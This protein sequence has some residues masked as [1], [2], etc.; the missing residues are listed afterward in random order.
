MAQRSVVAS[1]RPFVLEA[2]GELESFGDL[3]RLE[4]VI[5]Q[6]N[7]LIVQVLVSVTLFRKIISDLI[8]S[9]DRPMM[10]SEDN[11]GIGRISIQRF[12]KI[13]GPR[14]CVAN[15]RTADRIDVVEVVGCVFRRG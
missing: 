12:A 10:L 9:P 11:I 5:D 3:R 4:A 7:R 1:H 8:V 6:S 13:L 14:I 2:L 15:L